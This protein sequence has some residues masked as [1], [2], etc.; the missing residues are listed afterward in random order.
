MVRCTARPTLAPG[1]WASLTEALAWV[2][3][4]LDMV[5]AA[6]PVRALEVVLGDL[7]VTLG[8]EQVS[9]LIAYLGGDALV[10]FVRP[11]AGAH[12]NPAAADRLEMVT[13]AG[14]PYERTLVSQ[15]VQVVADGGRHR[16]FAPVTGSGRC[17]GRPRAGARATARR[18]PRRQDGVGAHAL[19]K[20]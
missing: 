12:E 9:F 2:A 10:R 17:A 1:T 19:A 16:L 4:L 18:R 6:A 15:Q 20:W 8:A 7:A 11:I 5:E 13:M 14:T 3:P